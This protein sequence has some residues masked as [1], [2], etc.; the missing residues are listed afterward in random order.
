MPSPEPMRQALV[1]TLI[2]A[3]AAAA[4]VVACVG[5]VL[6]DDLLLLLRLGD[7]GAPLAA[8]VAALRAK[9]AS[10]LTGLRG[11][12]G[13][14]YSVTPPPL[15]LPLGPPPPMPRVALED[16]ECA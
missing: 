5:V 12:I 4:A 15:L 10:R 2:E 1:G 11:L 8:A 13:L 6:P 3:L 14:S 7:P 16:G 9:T